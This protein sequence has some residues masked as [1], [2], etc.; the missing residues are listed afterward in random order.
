MGRIEPQHNQKNGQLNVAFRRKN[1]NRT[2]ALGVH[3][4]IANRI[5]AVAYGRLK[6]G[7]VIVCNGRAVAGGAVRGSGVAWDVDGGSTVAWVGCHGG[8][9]GQEAGENDGGE[10]LHVDYDMVD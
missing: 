7:D 9:G 6:G 3:P 10:G 1:H 2:Y 4:R 5:G 8:Y